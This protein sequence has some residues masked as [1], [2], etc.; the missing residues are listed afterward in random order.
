MSQAWPPG[1]PGQLGRRRGEESKPAPDLVQVALQK[2][3]TSPQRAVFVGDAVW[4]AKACGR[5]GVSCVG[6]LS[7]GTRRPSSAAPGRP[8]LPGSRGTA[9][10][11]PRH[12]PRVARAPSG[13]S[14]ACRAAGDGRRHP[15]IGWRSAAR[16]I[17]ASRAMRSERPQA[18]GRCEPW[19][20]A[21]TAWTNRP[22]AATPRH[23]PRR[24]AQSSAC[25][26]TDWSIA[27]TVRSTTAWPS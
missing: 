14:A 9:S 10:G 16:V 25:T 11:I 24:P 5:A 20:T 6:V 4:D 23:W 13:P 26:P 17:S 22:R 8:G 15:A 7:G 19:P 21:I 27:A 1:G 12:P 2:A 18:D 3:G